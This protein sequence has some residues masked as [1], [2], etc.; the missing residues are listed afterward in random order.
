[1][2]SKWEITMSLLD[3]DERE[4]ARKDLEGLLERFSERK[5]MM[6]RRIDYI[7]GVVEGLVLGIFGN[8]FV[9][10]L[11]PISEVLVLKKAFDILLWWN[12]VVV[13]S[14]FVVIIYVAMKYNNQLK[15]YKDRIRA[16]ES[17]EEFGREI[18]RKLKL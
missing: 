14:A 7:K 10:F 13:T 15:E 11:Y 5:E 9:Q 3:K 17:I 8:L 12:V 16:T 6:Q 1:M 18:M 2:L 4:S